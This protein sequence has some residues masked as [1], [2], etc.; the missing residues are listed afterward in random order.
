MTKTRLAPL[1]DNRLRQWRVDAGLTLA[2]VAD[3]VGLT[4]PH[5][6]RMERGQ[7]AVTPRQRVHIARCLGVTIGALFEVEP[8]EEPTD[9]PA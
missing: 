8:M 3:L 5:L 1:A 6:S 7:K 9:A 4:V 2:E